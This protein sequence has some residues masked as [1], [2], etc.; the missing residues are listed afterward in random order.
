MHQRGAIGRAVENLECL[1][2][3][4]AEIFRAAPMGDVAARFEKP[5]D[6]D[7]L[8]K[9]LAIV[10]SVEIGLVRRIDIHRGQQHSLSGERHCRR[11]NLDTGEATSAIAFITASLTP[12]SYSECP[13]LSTN[14]SSES[15]HTVLSSRAVAGGHSKS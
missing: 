10:P 2:R 6:R 7:A 9:M 5:V 1:G 4:Q 15:G 8:D 11:S 14:R 13:A 3:I 12:R